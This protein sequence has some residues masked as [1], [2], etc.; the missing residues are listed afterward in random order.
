M[1]RWLYEISRPIRGRQTLVTLSSAVAV[2][3]SCSDALVVKWLVD[4]GFR[5]GAAAGI[6]AA[7]A[8]FIGAF[9]ARIGLRTWGRM[10]AA[11]AGQR[12]MA[13]LRMR[14]AL[15]LSGAEATRYDGQPVGDLVLRL[16]DDVQTVADLMSYMLPHVLQVFLSLIVLA[17]V[18][19]AIDPPL[20]CAVIPLIPAFAMLRR[21]FRQP[22]EEAAEQRRSCAADRLS[23]LSEWL[24]G[25]LQVQMLSAERSFKRRLAKVSHLSFRT[26]MRQE[27]LEVLYSTAW[28]SL[29]GAGT[30]VVLGIGAA[31]VL[32]GSLT[33]GGY[34]A[35]YT[36]LGRLFDAASGTTDVYWQ[37]KRAA[38]SI[39]RLMDVDASPLRFPSRMIRGRGSTS[40]VSRLAYEHVHFGYTPGRPVIQDVSFQVVAGERIALIGRSGT[41]KSTLLKLLIG[42]GEL[43]SGSILLDERDIRDLDVRSLRRRVAFVPQAPFFFK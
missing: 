35:F 22:I 33:V 2:V 30:I 38:V 1:Y 27:R 18:M 36:Y 3:L 28:G 31:R 7:L 12:L 19:V 13:R 39:R 21:Q 29:L 6:F 34:V 40:G 32:H 11:T 20:T 42:S 15:R 4:K 10:T 23:F 26:A 9:S 37:V 8:I 41:G 5:D 16:D 43:W 25:M 14:I 24:A 17:S